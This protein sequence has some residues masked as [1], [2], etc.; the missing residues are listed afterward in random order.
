MCGVGDVLGFIVKTKI[1][2]NNDLEKV[3]FGLTR[4]GLRRAKN[5]G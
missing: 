5:W 2:T 1:D 3:S 4:P